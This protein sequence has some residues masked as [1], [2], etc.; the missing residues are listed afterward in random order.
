MWGYLRWALRT[1]SRWIRA[2]SRSMTL[3]M[4][5]VAGVVKIGPV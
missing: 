1:S 5:P 4:S 2:L 3:V